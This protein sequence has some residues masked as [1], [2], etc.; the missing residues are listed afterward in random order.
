MKNVLLRGPFLT[1]SGYGV[2]SRQLARW[3]LSKTDV[4]V[5]VQPLPWG[6]TP[7]LIDSTAQN[8]LIGEIMSRS[9]AAP[10]EKA[11]ITMQLQ[12][13]N[14]WDTSLGNFNVG[15]TAAVETDK[16]NPA[17]AEA[18]NKMNL[19]VVPSEHARQNLMCYGN[20]T[21]PVVVVPES[22]SDSVLKSTDQLPQSIPSFSTPFNLLVFGQITG[23]NPHNDRKNTFFT[24]KWLFEAFQN[25]PEVGIILKTNTGRHTMIDKTTTVNLIQQ[26]IKDARKGPYPKVHL[27]HGEMSDDEVAALYRAP[28]VKALVSLTRGEG[29][30]LPILEAA[31]SGVP[32]IA[33]GW[34]G[35]MDFMKQGKF[36]NVFYQVGDIHPSRIDNNIFIKGSR[37]ANPSEADF[38]KKIQK[39]RS[40]SSIPKEWALEL[41]QKLLTTH[42][43]EQISKRYDE[44]LK[45]VI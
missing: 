38:K 1:Q 35:Y 31:A 27:L 26:I 7:W 36:I 14:E 23:N 24:L 32:I 9:V 11:D 17:W 22:F 40:S 43:F 28:S 42:S 16:C 39:F 10:K 8:G 41:Q 3:V 19:V 30:G 20:V 12:L 37:W 33:T 4:K 34:S 13:P 45:E 25:D 18:C 21:T 6:N 5:S 44:A 2:H 15:L 29:Y